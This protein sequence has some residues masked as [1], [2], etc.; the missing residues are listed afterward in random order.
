MTQTQKCPAKNERRNVEFGNVIRKFSHIL[1]KIKGNRTPRIL[2]FGFIP[3][4]VWITFNE[5]AIC[6]ILKKLPRVLWN[7]EFDPQVT[8]FNYRLLRLESNELQKLWV[9]IDI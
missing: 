6:P 2:Q 4:Q 9:D 7:I 8:N 3:S 5:T 1:D